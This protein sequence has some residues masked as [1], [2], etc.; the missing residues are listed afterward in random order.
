MATTKTQG[1]Y[2]PFA[3][4]GILL[5]VLGGMGLLFERLVRVEE[6]V[7]VIVEV[8]AD[9]KAMSDR[10][11]RFIYYPNHSNNVAAGEL[12]PFK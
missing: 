6:Q 7:K 2:I 1:V 5:T 3:L 4:V 12:E 9:V 11:D 10:L 8:K